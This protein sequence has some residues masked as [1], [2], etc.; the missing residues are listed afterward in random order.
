MTDEIRHS[1]SEGA[2][3][4]ELTARERRVL[5]AVVR[6][7]VETAEPA[8][9]RNVVRRF[10]LG[11]SPATV[12]NTMSDLEERGYLFHPHASAGRVPTDLAYRTFVNHLMEPAALSI[13]EKERI[14]AELGDVGA[15]AVERLVRQATR[16]LG[17]LSQELGVAAAPR[18]TEAVLERLDLVRVSST[19]VLLVAQIRSGVVR[20]V[21]VDLP[22]EV[23]DD[24]LIAL[25]L[26]LNERLAGLTLQEIRESV[27]ERMRDVKLGI[28]PST[29]EILNIFVQSGSDIFDW[30][31]MQATEIHLGSASV[32]ASQ[33][34]FTSG[35]RLKG[36]LE[37]TERRELLAHV[38]GERPHTAGLQITI[39]GENAPQEL[40]EFTIVTG[41]YHVGGLRGVIGVIGPT[42]MPYEKVIAIVDYTST[43]M[44]HILK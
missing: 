9:S 20:T 21:Y 44:N 1:P 7:Y 36:L 31:E 18:L 17:L 39:G 27:S 34:E 33:P 22:C 4:T 29:D 30:P 24:T 41:E 6:T 23:P 8:G 15:S 13:A 35:E 32:L 37:L 25:A 3:G 12:R 38:L 40:A 14:E 28:D 5:E 19:K 10:E 43:L 16:A 2:D 11:V 42:R 26:L